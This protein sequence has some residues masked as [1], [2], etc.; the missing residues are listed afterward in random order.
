MKIYKLLCAALLC[1]L[2]AACNNG[3]GESTSSEP[4]EEITTVPV[5][6]KPTE[7]SKV[8]DCVAVGREETFKY[9]DKNKNEVSVTYRVPSLRFDTAAAKAINAE[10]TARYTD[11]FT[12]AYQATAAGT[13]PEYAGI[14]YSAFVNDDIVTL[15]ITEESAGHSLSYRVFN[16][17]KTTGERLDNDGLLNYLGLEPDE[18]YSELQT[19]LKADYTSKFK[20]ENFPKDYYY[21]LELT[22]GDEAVRESQL[23]LNADAELYAVCKEYAGV[24]SGEFSVLIRC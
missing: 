15:L 1:L 23:F 18:A 22:A 4:P 14:N 9:T 2:L 21:K 6:T 16:Y 3:G 24:G 7:P 11:A 8:T 20:E 17:N 12:S 13:A 5:T 19:A 10:I